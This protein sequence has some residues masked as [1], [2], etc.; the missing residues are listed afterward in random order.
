[1]RTQLRL[2]SQECLGNF[3]ACMERGKRA[4]TFQAALE[5]A[6]EKTTV[7]CTF[8]QFRNGFPTLRASQSE[9]LYDV[10]VSYVQTVRSQVIVRIPHLLSPLYYSRLLTSFPTRRMN[11][12]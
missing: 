9:L 12:T 2:F 1:M 6:I 10:Y 5:K 8:E 11:S 7:S 3:G 4:R